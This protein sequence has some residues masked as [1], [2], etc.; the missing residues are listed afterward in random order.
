MLHGASYAEARAWLAAHTGQYNWVH[1]INNAG[2][3]AVALL[4]GE[5]DFVTTVGRS[6]AAG[7]DTDSNAA[8]V[9]SVFGALYGAG[10]IPAELR[11]AGGERLTSAVPGFDGI[12]IAT[13]AERS[14][15]L[16]E[17]AGAGD[18]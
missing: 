3:I 7:L 5:E 4:W 8:T 11:A 16:A 18:H 14:L 6:V 17:Q 13:L 15:R 10:A 12:E 9:G 1:T 2:I